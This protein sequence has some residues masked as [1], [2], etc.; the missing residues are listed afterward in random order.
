MEEGYDLRYNEAVLPD[1]DMEYGM[2]RI[3]CILRERER[4]RERERV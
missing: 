3:A 1:P 4:E 2:V